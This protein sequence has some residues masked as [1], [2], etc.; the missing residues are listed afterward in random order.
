[1]QGNDWERPARWKIVNASA[2]QARNPWLRLPSP[3]GEVDGVAQ[4]PIGLILSA[5]GMRESAT[6]YVETLIIE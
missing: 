3:M 5:S 2:V 6:P 1:M 4:L